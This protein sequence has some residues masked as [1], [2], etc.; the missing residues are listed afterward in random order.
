V[1]VGILVA[2]F[3]L[4]DLLD[5]DKVGYPAIAAL[6]FFASAGMV[7]PVPGMASV[8]AGGWQ[9]DPL[10]VALVAGATGT[11]GELTG[12][13]LGYSGSGIARKGRI[14]QRIEGWMKRRGWLVIFL[15]SVLPNP[16]FDLAG[17]SAGV[18]RYPVRWF[19]AWIWVG[20]FLKFLMVAYAC[21]FSV[22]SV[23]GFF[24][25]GG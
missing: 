11:V 13:M 4:K 18:L 23:M 16:I 2:V 12:Y 8:C 5:L 7:I 21:A 17:I 24:G 14:Y 1:V 3:L 19:L 15:L 25:V 9:L 20:T 22:D 10:T 6:S